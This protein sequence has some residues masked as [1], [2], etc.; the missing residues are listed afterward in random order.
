[1]ELM[2]TEGFEL[3]EGGRAK[4]KFVANVAVAVK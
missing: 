4:L 2:K 1:M 3:L